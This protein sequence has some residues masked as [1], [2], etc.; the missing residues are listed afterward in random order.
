MHLSL[1]FKKRASALFVLVHSD[2]WGPCLV[3]SLTG[4]KYFIIIV[5]DISHVTWIYLMKIH[6]ELFSHFTALYD[7]IKT[8][9]HVPV[10]ILRSDNAK[11]YLSEHFQSFML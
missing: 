3:M 2:V 1:R 11:E 8:Q 4:F 6:S 10:Q 5:D 9:F 7:E